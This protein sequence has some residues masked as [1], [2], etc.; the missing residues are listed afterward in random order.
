[1]R[2]VRDGQVPKDVALQAFSL[3]FQ[4]DIPGVKLPGGVPGDDVPTSGT[5]VVRWVEAHRGELSPE[6][7][8]VIERF[9]HPRPDDATGSARSVRGGLGRTE[10]RRPRRRCGRRPSS[11]ATTAA[12]RSVIRSR[13]GWT[14]RSRPT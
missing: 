1:M 4:V 6:Q 5:G 12:D 11:T 3:T 8:A 9:V 7:M 13:P 2:Q 10:P 14:T